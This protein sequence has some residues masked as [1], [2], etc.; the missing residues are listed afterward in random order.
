MRWASFLQNEG[1][2]S[3]FVI[4]HHAFKGNKARRLESTLQLSRLYRKQITY[5]QNI[6]NGHK[7]AMKRIKQYQKFH[8]EI[9]SVA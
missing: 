6:D 2:M 8:L 5:L 4:K 3:V 7:S 1:K 9:N